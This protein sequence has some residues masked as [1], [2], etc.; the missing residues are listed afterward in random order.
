V[1]ERVAE[2][3]GS[4]PELTISARRVSTSTVLLS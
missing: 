3:K 1:V 2:Q 4:R